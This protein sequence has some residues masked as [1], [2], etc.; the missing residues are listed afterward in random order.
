MSNFQFPNCPPDD[1][2]T[3][4]PKPFPRRTSQPISAYRSLFILVALVLSAPSPLSA[5]SWEPPTHRGID[6]TLNEDFAPAH[7]I[8]DSLMLA[9]PNRPE[10]L[11]YKAVVFW[12]QGMNVRDG[13][14]YDQELLRYLGLS[15]EATENWMK[16]NGE[17]A[18]MFLWLG[19][20]YGLRTGLQML[21]REVFKGITDG[22][23]G[24]ENLDEAI[25]LDPNLT[26]ANFGI[27]LSDY[28]L[29]R[30]PSI[31][32][33][34][35][36]LFNLPAGD[37]YGGLRRLDEAIANGRYNRTDALSARAYLDLYYEMD[38]QSA[39]TRFLDLLEKYPNSLDYRIRYVDTMLRL[40]ME[41]GED[42]AQTMVDSIA[43][44]H[45]IAFQRK[46]QL[47]RWRETKLN[48]IKGMSHFI[49]GN[50]DRARTHLTTS[51]ARSR[52]EDNWL[53]GPAELTLGKIADL[54]GKRDAAKEHYK[55]AERRDDVWESRA[56]AKRYQ[57]KAYTGEEPATHPVD[58]E[59]RY[60]GR[61]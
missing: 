60:P 30:N 27:G 46:W 33:V 22:I 45:R 4:L 15:I 53:V 23:E 61:P 56:E 2:E 3:G 41:H 24:R 11:F 31:L 29:S 44:I 57:I 52:D 32:R 16:F 49:L 36:R 8:F 39:R 13:K 25:H 51:A 1:R 28:I 21:R 19:N 59:I 37:R 14:K 7:A 17:S 12:R 38:A 35:Q 47:F 58:Y 26:D 40:Q 6:L 50:H 54:A 48:F 9:H 5:Q 42:L 10:P 43:S 18:E 34:V 55:R 20:A